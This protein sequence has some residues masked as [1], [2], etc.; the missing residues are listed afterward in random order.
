MEVVTLSLGLLC[1]DHVVQLSGLQHALLLV[2]RRELFLLRHIL[3]FLSLVVGGGFFLSG[4]LTVGAGHLL[5]DSSQSAAIV[6]AVLF[7]VVL[8]HVDVYAVVPCE[9]LSVDIEGRL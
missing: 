4:E 1:D 8:V 6:E 3:L 5:S 2:G 9:R 7:V